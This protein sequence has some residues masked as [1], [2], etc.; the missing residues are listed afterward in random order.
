MKRA[1]RGFKTYCRTRWL[2]FA[3][4][5]KRLEDIWVRYLSLC[6]FTVFTLATFHLT[7]DT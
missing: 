2:G 6:S 4:C 7:L 3:V 5:V 1:G